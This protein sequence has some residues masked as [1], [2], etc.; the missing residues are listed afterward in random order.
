M[1]EGYLNCPLCDA[2]IPVSGEEGEGSQVY[3]SFCSA[4]LKLKKQKG[5][6]GDQELYCEEDF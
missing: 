1:T 2:E 3:C 5:G 4:M 6:D